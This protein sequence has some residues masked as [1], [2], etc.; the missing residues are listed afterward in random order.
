MA[1]GIDHLRGKMELAGSYSP[2]H[3]GD[4]YDLMG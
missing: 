1:A 2:L 3:S 4:S